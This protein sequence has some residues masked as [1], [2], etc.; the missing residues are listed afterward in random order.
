M[1]QLWVSEMQTM[2]VLRQELFA[3]AILPARAFVLQ[4]LKILM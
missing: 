2:R 1:V 4:S 3:V